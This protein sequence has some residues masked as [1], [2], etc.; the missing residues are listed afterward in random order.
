MSA[1]PS[2]CLLFRGGRLIDGT[3]ARA[4]LADVLV[5]D[6]RIAAVGEISGGTGARVIDIEG[7]V[8]APGFI[9]VHTHDDRLLLAEPAMAPKVSQGVTTVIVGNC[10]L[11]LAGLVTAG[12]APPPLDLLD[13]AGGGFRFERFAEYVDA[14]AAR[15]A[16]TNV[17]M[18][19]G[20]STLRVAAMGGQTDR[21]AS[22]EH[23]ARMIAALDEA[24]DAGALGLSTG[25]FYPPAAAADTGELVELSS[26]VAD[27]GGLYV[28]HMRDEG[29]R[30][31]AAIA[32]TLHIGRACAMPVVVSH[33][34][35]AG[36]RNH[37][38]TEQTL[39]TL[40][41]AM[42]C[43]PVG[44]DCYPYSASSTMLD[45]GRVGLA[46]RVRIAWSAPHPEVAGRDLDAV[47]EAW[48][49]DVQEAVRRLQPAGAIYFMMSEA[50][51]RRVL[52]FPHTMI[53][54]DGLPHD[55]SPHPRL[56]G[57]FPRVLGHYARD[58]GLFA[59]E[60]A[61]RKMTG[62]PAER[63]GLQGRGRLDVGAWADL[64]VFDPG[65]II[66]RAT[67]DRPTEPAA[68]IR[69]VVVNGRPVW[70]DGAPT[71][72]RPGRFIRRGLAAGARR[73]SV[74]VAARA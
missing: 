9:D 56:W 25:T 41:A 72:E 46:S 45:A 67:W 31:D 40:A 37:G 4:R 6:D 7:L 3:G 13:P 42:A 39:A 16:A 2:G 29:D 44:L 24:M 27:R 51:V 63:F 20:H 18:L 73:E 74:P 49:V 10:G 54:S 30:I 48:G 19:A 69:M 53:G 33:H 68:G 70:R 60:E 21:P 52:S 38:R 55:A 47:A 43:Q 8:I 1:P 35:V 71:G 61:V 22:P 36:T 23:R 58:V 59:L 26:R 28:T 12:R 5:E 66:D 32:E 17:A 62:L 65:S 50:D 64:T 34:K 15:P 11:S 57:T 14:L